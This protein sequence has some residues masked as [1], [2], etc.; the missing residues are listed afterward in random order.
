ML[1][2]I[3]AHGATVG[4]LLQRIHDLGI[5]TPWSDSLPAHH[6]FFTIMTS[7]ET[8]VEVSDQRFALK[9]L[10]VSQMGENLAI[11]Y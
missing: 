2:A 1:R 3:G 10:I 8:F 11:F 9:E 5:K 4:Y 6:A 7:D